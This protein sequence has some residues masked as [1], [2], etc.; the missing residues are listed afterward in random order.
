[1]EHRA[2]AA[3]HQGIHPARREVIMKIG[4]TDWVFDPNYRVYRPKRPFNPRGGAI[5]QEER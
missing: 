5:Q 2:I 3:H 4:D 1:M